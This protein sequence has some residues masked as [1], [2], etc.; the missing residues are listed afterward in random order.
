MKE[1]EKVLRKAHPHD[2]GII[3]EAFEAIKARKLVGR[4]LKGSNY[5]KVRVGRFRVTYY[6]T[7]EG[8]IEIDTVR[9]RNEKTY[10]DF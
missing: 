2:R 4:K 1:Y 5:Y 6:F 8:K 3:E 9:P 10:R 7:A